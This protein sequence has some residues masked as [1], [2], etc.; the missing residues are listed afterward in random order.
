MLFRKEVIEMNDIEVALEL[1]KLILDSRKVPVKTGQDSKAEILAT[2]REAL[3]A[4][5]EKQD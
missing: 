2:Y 4:V 1:T 3:A 5:R